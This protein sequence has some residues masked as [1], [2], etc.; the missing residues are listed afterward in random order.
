MERDEEYDG[1]KENRLHGPRDPQGVE[2]PRMVRLAL[3]E[4]EH[5]PQYQTQ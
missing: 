2:L 5:T 4:L 1:E 3:V